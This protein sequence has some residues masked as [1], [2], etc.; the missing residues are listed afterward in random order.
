[1]TWT[2]TRYEGYGYS[3]S[4]SGAK[5]YADA[6]YDGLLNYGHVPGY[7][8]QADYS[9]FYFAIK[10]GADWTFSTTGDA[11]NREFQI[12]V[13]TV[14][15]GTAGVADYDNYGFGYDGGF[16]NG[17]FSLAVAPESSGASSISV[18]LDMTVI[19]PDWCAQPLGP[20]LKYWGKGFKMPTATNDSYFGVIIYPDN[21]FDYN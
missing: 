12:Y 1:L 6:R 20:Q 15:M 10:Y 18:S 13:K 19:P 14:G 17:T 4:W 8:S 7:G 9:G 3:I 11:T 2:T 21:P 5:T 16:K